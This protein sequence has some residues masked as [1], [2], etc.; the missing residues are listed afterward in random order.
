MNW[1]LVLIDLALIVLLVL[2]MYRRRHGR[3]DLV[4]SFIGANAG[5]LVVASALINV[6]S[7]ASLG[8]G[9][10]LFGVLSIIRLRSTELEQHDVAYFFSSLAMGLIAGIGVGQVWLTATL[11]GLPVL[12]LAIVD[13]PRFMAGSRRQRMVVDRAIADENAL[14]AYLGQLLG[15]HVSQVT[16]IQ[17]DFV[18]D[19]TIVDV[20]YRL[21]GGS[22]AA[23]AASAPVAGTHATS[24]QVSFHNTTT[25]EEAATAEW[26]MNP[27]GVASESHAHR[28][29]GTVNER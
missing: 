17:T 21:G 1:T 3:K 13:H 27:Q 18:L 9:L 8:V 7:T 19:K 6:S 16:V 11:M 25:D 5:V 26:G 20:T 12:V 22:P 4:V 14:C 10:G 23:P 2:G 28:F 15:A 29:A 24:P